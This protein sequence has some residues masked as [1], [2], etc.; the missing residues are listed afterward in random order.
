MMKNKF[1]QI[2]VIGLTVLVFGC[3]K[4][5]LPAAENTR[6]REE[7]EKTIRDVERLEKEM[8]EVW[9]L[10]RVQRETEKITNLQEPAKPP[11][12]R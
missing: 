9:E 12:D 8:Q 2:F 5:E 11:K 1:W 10:E 3:S 6:T 4:V 7:A